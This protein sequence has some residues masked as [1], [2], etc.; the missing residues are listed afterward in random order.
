[1]EILDT[2]AGLSPGQRV[3]FL[4]IGLLAASAEDTLFRGYI[5]PALMTR[6]GAV[7]GVVLT[8][9]LFQVHHFTD[10]PTVDR[11]GG[12]CIIGL[13]FGVL[14]WQKRP[15]IA[16]YTAHTVLWLIWGNT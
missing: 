15:L 14:R 3:F 10:W 16:A 8:M 7:A 2:I 4:G 5:Q 1:T 12:L 6:F 9:V 13:G 11:I